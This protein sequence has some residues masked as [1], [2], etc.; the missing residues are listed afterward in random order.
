MNRLITLDISEW[1]LLHDNYMLPKRIADETPF[2]PGL[3]TRTFEIDT[4]LYDDIVLGLERVIARCRERLGAVE[5][6]K[7]K[8]PGQRQ[9]A[10]Q[11]HAHIAKSLLHRLWVI[12]LG[13]VG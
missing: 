12:P 1:A 6:K 3:L 2:N 5:W 8:S 13:G 4:D 10:M 11:A 9:D 7:G